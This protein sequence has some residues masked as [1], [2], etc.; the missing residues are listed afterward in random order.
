MH[1]CET[2]NRY[3]PNMRPPQRSLFSLP[4]KITQAGFP[5][6]P[7]RLLTGYRRRPYLE[8]ARASGCWRLSRAPRRSSRR[9]GPLRRH[10]TSPRAGSAPSAA[11]RGQCAAAIQRSV[12]S[13]QGVVF[14]RAACCSDSTR[15]RTKRG[16]RSGSR[17]WSR[18]SRGHDVRLPAAA[19]PII[20]T[21][22]IYQ[23]RLSANEVFFFFLE[24]RLERALTFF[25][26]SSARVSSVAHSSASLRFA[27]SA[28]SRPLHSRSTSSR[29]ARSGAPRLSS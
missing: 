6:L 8:V 24:C 23:L 25:S 28:A 22:I 5:S 4:F 7:A 12:A 18:T 17:T 3:L 13:A 15:T 27:S 26:F 19:V 20:P 1:A 29:T 10:P 2:H 11:R 14:V 21:P 16:P 9:R